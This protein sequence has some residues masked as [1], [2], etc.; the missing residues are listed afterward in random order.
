MMQLTSKQVRCLALLGSCLTTGYAFPQQSPVRPPSDSSAATPSHSG[1]N[2][3]RLQQ[4]EQ[5][6]INNLVDVLKQK[7]SPGLAMH[8]T[9]NPT[10]VHIVAPT[11]DSTNES[12]GLRFSDMLHQLD[13]ALVPAGDLQAFTNYRIVRPNVD[14]QHYTLAIPSGTPPDTIR[15]V[16]GVPDNGG[17]GVIAI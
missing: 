8:A 12:S 16:Y 15:K 7:T 13:P 17:A 3:M 10:A 5:T 11:S 14:V 6:R 4:S 1:T 2:Y 9:Q